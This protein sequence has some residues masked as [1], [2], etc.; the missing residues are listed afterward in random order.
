M[1]RRAVRASIVATAL[2]GGLLAVPAGP[3]LGAKG[4][5]TWIWPST[6]CNGTLQAC[7]DGAFTGDAV[8]IDSNA[9]VTQ[10]TTISK[11]LTLRLGSGYHASLE[12]IFVDNETG[13]TGITVTLHNLNVAGS[14]RA[15]LWNGPTNTLTITKVAV[16]DGVSLGAA[17]D[18]DVRTDATVNVSGN[19]LKAP[20]SETDGLDFYDG[21]A[22]ADITFD[23]V[24]NR[25]SARGNTNSGYG[26]NLYANA[27]GT[28]A[29]HL[30]NNSVA[31][32]ATCGCG[33]ATAI[34]IDGE[35][36]TSQVYD[37]V[38]N[39]VD[40]SGYVGIDVFSALTLPGSM[41][42]NLFNNIVTRSSGQNV[43]VYDAGASPMTLHAGHNNSHG[44]GSAND[45]GGHSPGTGNLDVSPRYVDEA[46]GNLALKASSPVIDAGLVCSPGGVAMQD[47]AGH[48]RLFGSSVDLGAYEHGAG[49]PTGV[50]RV[51]GSAGET[52]TG[53]PGADILCGLG[54]ADLLKGKGGNDYLDGGS[55]KDVID[56]GKGS[57]RLFGGTGDDILCARD[58]K[59]GNDH[60][61]GGPGTDKYDTDPGDTRTSVE[62]AFSCFQ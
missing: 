12:G 47:A 14:V 42:V 28:F 35:G 52:L 13:S 8:E 22:P 49:A 62:Q 61:D 33:G 57:D 36:T 51:G 5:G 25:V 20:G 37:V 7:I 11:S 30:Y 21:G 60:L 59:H 58:G 44:G 16:V 24:G 40:R 45:F 23:M 56:G 17:I 39:S 32:T 31:A 3:A 53:T 34:G 38:G 15:R 2:L 43:S 48:A 46:H 9:T 19:S 4:P 41:S 29:A 55:G 27:S 6:G 18:L 26:I 54:G 50:A 1:R 10:E